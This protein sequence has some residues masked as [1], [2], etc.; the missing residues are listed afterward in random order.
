MLQVPRA[1]GRISGAVVAL[2]GTL[3]AAEAVAVPAIAY[4]AILAMESVVV[5]SLFAIP[6]SPPCP[7]DRH[8]RA[9]TI[10]FRPRPCTAAA[11]CSPCGV[12][13]TRA[14]VVC[15]AGQADAKRPPDR[16]AGQA[17][18]ALVAA[19]RALLSLADKNLGVQV[20]CTE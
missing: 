4:I 5:G 8:R 17:A 11:R 10:A 16:W 20:V 13:P 14:C 2:K 3:L 15:V 18:V 7:P 19:E 1:S 12:A 6:A 9:K